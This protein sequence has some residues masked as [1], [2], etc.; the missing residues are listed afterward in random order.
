MS[1]ELPADAVGRQMQELWERQQELEDRGFFRSSLRV[2]RELRRLAKTERRLIP[3]IRATLAITHCALSTFETELGMELATEMVALL[4]SEDHARQFQP[5]FP[6][7]E[8]QNVVFWLST[9][10]Y[11]HLGSHAAIRYGYGSPRIR[12]VVREGNEV[13]RRTG[14]IACLDCFRDYT[15]WVYLTLGDEQT[16]LHFA[17]SIENKLPILDQG[18]H[19]FEG[20]RMQA[21][22]HLLCG[23]LTEAADQSRRALELAKVYHTPLLAKL[24]AFTLLGSALFLSGRGDELESLCAEVGEPLDWSLFP[25]EDENPDLAWSKALFDAVVAVSADRPAEAVEILD[26]WDR[27]LAHWEAIPQWLETRTRLISVLR[28]MGK[29]RQADGL[30]EDLRQRVSGGEAALYHARLDA[31]AS[32]KV[33]PTAVGF[34]YP[35]RT[36][37]IPL[38]PLTR[39]AAESP[40]DDQPPAAAEKA[41]IPAVDWDKTPMGPRFNAWFERLPDGTDAEAKDMEVILDEMLAVDPRDVEL[42]EDGSRLIF[43]AAQLA[44]ALRREKD[45]WYWARRL[46]ERFPEHP[47]VLN[48]AATAGLGAWLRQ[49]QIVAE[50]QRLESEA[51]DETSETRGD[52]AA[53]DQ[54]PEAPADPHLPDQ[55]TLEHLMRKS[56][57]LKPDHPRHY[58]RAG[59][60][61]HVLGLQGDAEWC[62]ARS[63]ALD[64]TQAAAALALAEVYAESK[65]DEDALFVLDLCLREGKVEDADVAWEAGLAAFRLERYAEAATYFNLA[66]QWRSAHPWLPYYY[67][68]ALLQTNRPD[69]AEPLIE[70]FAELHGPDH[71]AA[72]ALQAWLAALRGETDTLRDLVQAILGVPLREVDDLTPLGIEKNLRQLWQVVKD[73]L[74][75]DDPLQSELVAR[76]FQAGMVPDDF[77]EEER[78]RRPITEGLTYYECAVEQPLD[79]DW[80][81]HPA[82]LVHQVN[83]REY[84]ASWGVLA[85][86]EEEAEHYVIQAQQRCYPL[87]PTLM[88]CEETEVGFRD[89]PGVV[90]QG[91]RECPDEYDEETQER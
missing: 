49:A 87:P 17:R 16:A 11:H 90:W 42:P 12:D 27:R 68:W 63:F 7:D 2:A 33:A 4:E 86:N 62:F 9:C 24:D 80:P 26:R 3:Y 56:L 69:E 85:R 71:F 48:L 70:T 65:R 37:R 23:R 1:S 91:A 79:D 31:M 38:P 5:D 39:R 67:A 45:V 64:R 18:D 25:P 66:G 40:G 51:A 58:Y 21:F 76:L 81:K 15:V 34:L 13:C 8:Y 28:L 82:C 84:Y 74:P 77:F 72:R 46:L 52:V 53:S 61:F 88:S 10:A 41:P 36:D 60:L 30:E 43:V 44:S 54:P 78:A 14:K 73:Y 19:R 57:D 75:A 35:P 55:Q 50:R 29:D 89:R 32:G 83:W 6:D 59:V 47:D 20:A 22:I